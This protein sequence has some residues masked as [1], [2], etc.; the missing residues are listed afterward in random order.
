[1][2]LEGVGKMAALYSMDFV[3]DASCLRDI[4]VFIC[5]FYANDSLQKGGLILIA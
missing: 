3:Y 2:Y 5:L 4:S 1:M